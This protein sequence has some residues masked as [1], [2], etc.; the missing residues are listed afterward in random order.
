MRSIWVVLTLIALVA[1]GVWL[2]NSSL[3]H[4]PSA[5]ATTRVLAHRGVHQTFPTKSL[6]NDSC[7]ATLIAPPRHPFLE[8]T[9]ASMRAA[10]DAGADVVELDVHLTP[11]GKFA[12][13]HDWTLD[14]R[15][16]GSGVT[17]QTPFSVLKTLD[18]GYGYTADG[19][20]SF[21]FR[22]RAKGLM[23]ELTEVFEAFP[24]GKFLIN[25]KSRRAEE[26]TALATLIGERPEFRASIF[27]VYGGAEPTRAAIAS[28]AG[29]RGYDRDSMKACI[30][31]YAAL[32]WSGYVPSQCRETILALPVNIARWLWGWPHRF[33]ARMHAAGT[34][35]I[36]LGPWDGGASAGIDHETELGL[37]SPSFGG[38]VWTNR[39]ET[40]AKPIKER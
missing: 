33:V 12:V 8:N 10:F 22:G 37:V 20:K 28:L 4:G 31:R 5:E 30:M 40:M 26:G 19:G 17:E 23:P 13:F 39:T 6:D 36:L 18:V 27:G 9:I 21:P 16:D 3:L 11:D 32:G 2:N 24:Q 1:A 38:L 7:T 29:L 25:Y 35:V 34:E 14:C 15:T